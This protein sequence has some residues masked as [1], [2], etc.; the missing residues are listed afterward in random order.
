M[1]SKYFSEEWKKEM[2]DTNAVSIMEVKQYILAKKY[3]RTVHDAMTTG[4]YLYPILYEL[5]KTF[6]TPASSAAVER[7]FSMQ[8]RLVT[9]S[10]NRLALDGVRDL[11]FIK[12][13]V[14]S[15]R[16][17]NWFIDMLRYLNSSDE[18]KSCI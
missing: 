12:M 17:W 13:N 11:L 3:R 7:S 8:N 6:N 14:L 18:Q 10:R 9:P 4:R 15:A 2:K 5:Y 16:K 1:K